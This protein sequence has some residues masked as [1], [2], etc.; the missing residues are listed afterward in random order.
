MLARAGCAV[1]NSWST[2]MEE[3]LVERIVEECR[4]SARRAREIIE[5]WRDD[6][7]LFCDDH[8]GDVLEARC[9][10]RLHE[11]EK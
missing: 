1:N 9:I 5:S 4:R 6:G 10:V 11:S 8:E 3:E 7:Y 2:G